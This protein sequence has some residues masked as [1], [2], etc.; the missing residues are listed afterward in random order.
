MRRSISDPCIYFN[1]GKST[2]DL[3]LLGIWVDYGFLGTKTKA[4]AAAMIQYLEKFFEMTSKPA[5]LFIGLAI[6]RKR[7]EKKI[8]ISQPNYIRSL[9]HKFK[10]TDC[11]PSKVPADP[12]SRLTVMDCPLR[13]GSTPLSSN[14]YRSAVGGLMYAAKMTRPDILF[15]V[16]AASRYNQDPGNAHWAAV[17]RIL[18]YL[19]GTI[20]HGLCFGETD[21]VD[22]LVT[23]SDSDFAGCQ[24]IRR[25]ISGLLFPFNGG[26][27]SWTSNLQ[28]PIANSTA[29][30]EYYAAGHASRKIAWLRSLLKEIGFEQ[31]DPTPLLCDNKSAMLM[32]QN[33]VFHNR[34][35]HIDIKYHYLC[36]TKPKSS[37]YDLSAP[38]TN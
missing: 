18:S 35:K 23:Y 31:F 28:K 20:N 11:N 33:P 2:D 30:A 34:T 8:F 36:S 29:E 21:S 12:R 4:K 13:S 22:H 9:L 10:M 17:K 26:P 5:S 14:P 3:T 27:V 32:V 15:A 19:A 16:T 38:R 24:D 7:D 1:Q 6:T 25:S 37:N